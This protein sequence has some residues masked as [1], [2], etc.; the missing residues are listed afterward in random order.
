VA[1][2]R[3]GKP[4]A[5]RVGGHRRVGR[6]VEAEAC[7]GPHDLASHAARAHTPQRDA[8]R[9]SVHSGIDLIDGVHHCPNA[10]TVPEVYAAAGLIRALQLV[11]NTEAPG[12]DRRHVGL[13]LHSAL[14]SLTERKLRV[15]IEAVAGPRSGARSASERADELLRSLS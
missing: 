9:A 2:Q 14:L 1:R 5:R 6:L 4:P 12:V 7:L 8:V 13:D 15:P 3:L 10:V 11:G